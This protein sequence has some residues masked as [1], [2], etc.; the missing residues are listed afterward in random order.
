[1]KNRIDIELY[2]EDDFY[3]AYIGED[4]SSGYE[5][6]ETTKESCAEGVKQYVINTFICK[7]EN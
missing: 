3:C 5:I 2:K 6:K 4:G 1:M 7:D